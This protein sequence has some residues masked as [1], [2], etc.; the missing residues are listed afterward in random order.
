MIDEGLFYEDDFESEFSIF[1]RLDQQRVLE[2]RKS[3]ERSYDKEDNGW[4]GY[5]YPSGL[6]WSMC[7]AKHIYEV[8][9]KPKVD[10]QITIKG[11]EKKVIGSL[12][13]EE[14]NNLL[15]NTRLLYGEPNYPQ[16]ILDKWKEKPPKRKY[17]EIYI[18]S[19]RWKV[20]GW[21]D[22]VYKYK[23][24]P[25]VGDFKT[26]NSHPIK[27]WNKEKEELPSESDQ[28]QCYIYTVIFTEDKYFDQDIEGIRLC[29]Y[30]NPCFGHQT[31]NPKYEWSEKIQP[32]K[33]QKTIMLLDECAN[34]VLRYQEG[35][36]QECNYRF[37][38]EHSNG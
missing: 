7:V 31:I 23:Q 17:P 18:W 2:A 26:K 37:C 21:A 13:H 14:W 3:E 27:D 25:W 16:M 32:E 34:Q 10:F 1:A 9:T 12:R 30:N 4:Q 38:K 29:Y 28:T 36:P 22:L 8:V 24:K 6:S 15:L 20:R 5:L 35:K 33:Y 11:E 19:E